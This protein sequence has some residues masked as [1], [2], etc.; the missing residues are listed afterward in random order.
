MNGT[1]A[2]P[3]AVD[4]PTCLNC[5]PN[6]PAACIAPVAA[7]SKYGLL[8]CLGRNATLSVAPCC[9]PTANAGLTTAAVSPSDAT[10]ASTGVHAYLTGNLIFSKTP[11]ASNF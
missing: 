4:G 7:V 3:V 10:P 1:W 2:A 8:T 5:P 11:L 9:A 6:S